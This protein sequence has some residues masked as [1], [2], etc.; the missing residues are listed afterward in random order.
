LCPGTCIG[1]LDKHC[2]AIRVR[3][4]EKLLSGDVKAV[5]KNLE[6]DMK[7]LAKE[8]KFEAAKILR[9]KIY[10]LQHINDISLIK[11]D[12]LGPNAY[13]LEPSFRIEAYDIA[14]MSGDNMVGVM[15]VVEGGMPNKSQYRK[16]KINTVT[17]S[18]D[19]KAL[20]EVLERRFE[21]TEWPFPQLVVVDGGVAQLNTAKLVIARLPSPAASSNGGQENLRMNIPV[22][23]VVKDQKHKAK[24]LLGREDLVTKYKKEAILANAESHRFAIAFHKSRRSK[25]FLP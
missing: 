22:I 4:I 10:A 9:D 5:V 19:P 23:A 6:R 21:H 20:K 25:N 15:T 7:S 18:N 11:N 14:H 8:K 2:Y 16:F 13:G 3:R 17:S 1:A 12:L 24:G